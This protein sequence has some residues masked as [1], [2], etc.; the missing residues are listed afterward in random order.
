MKNNNI[1][2]LRGVSILLVIFTHLGIFLKKSD[3][4]NFWHSYF[5]TAIGVDFFFIIS[6]YLMGETFLKKI[7]GRMMTCEDAFVFYKRRFSRLYL[8]CFFWA[9][10]IF[11]L[12]WVWIEQGFFKEF[13][14]ILGVVLGA[15]TFTGN[16]F[17][18]TMPNVFGYF[19]SLGVEMQFYLFL[20]LLVAISI[21]N[22]WVPCIILLLLFTVIPGGIKT[23]WMFR[24]N[25]LFIGLL[26]WF[27]T[28]LA[29]FEMIKNTLN[30]QHPAMIVTVFILALLSASFLSYPYQRFGGVAYT[31][32][33]LILS[34]AFVATSFYSRPVF[35]VFNN[36]LAG[37]GN[38]SFS[39]YLC[40][41][42]IF[43]LVKYFL[44]S[45]V[46]S[47]Y[48]LASVA[49]LSAIITAFFSYQLLEKNKLRE[50][51]M[52]TRLN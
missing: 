38:I 1:Q 11:V 26:V 28:Q 30:K 39:L 7:D 40:H 21:R 47:S 37:I 15:I 17:N 8:P 2:M 36:M 51:V 6:G 19:W 48:L 31:I 33:A 43:I 49:I 25:A 5:D 35:G 29:P 32:T 22:R 20:P 4:F 13:R 27:I 14:Q 18:A 24:A 44:I 23:W 34:I 12:S 46:H 50:L 10:F 16:F 52:K 9:V 45:R 41:L 3:V 42:P